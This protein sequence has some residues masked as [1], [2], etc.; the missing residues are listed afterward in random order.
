MAVPAYIEVNRLALA[1]DVSRGQGETLAGLAKLMGCKS[2]KFGTT[3]KSHYEK[4]FVD[5]KMDPTGIEA[6]INSSIAQDKANTCGA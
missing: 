2:D 1:E 4:I 5:T 6:E 3:L